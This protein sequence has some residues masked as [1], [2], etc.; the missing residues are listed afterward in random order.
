[1]RAPQP[2]DLARIHYKNDFGEPRTLGAM[3]FVPADGSY[4]PTWVSPDGY[5][6][7]PEA[8]DNSDVV[9]NIYT[10]QSDQSSRPQSRTTDTGGQS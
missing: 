10:A 9:G 8:V 7:D 2:G 4:G 3:Y 6:I 1:M 5:D